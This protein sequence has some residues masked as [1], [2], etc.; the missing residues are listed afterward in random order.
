M[1]GTACSAPELAGACPRRGALRPAP[2]SF[3][4]ALPVL[5]PPAVRND[6]DLPQNNCGGVMEVDLDDNWSGTKIRV[7]GQLQKWEYTEIRQGQPR[8][9][10]GHWKKAARCPRGRGSRAEI[11]RLR[12]EAM[13]PGSMLRAWFGG[14][15]VLTT[16]HMRSQC[17]A[18]CSM[19]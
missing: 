8:A 7:R 2:L 9:P 11:R 3:I 6:I 18:P 19:S 17:G 16:N 4:P 14:V 13:L 12:I 5:L 1:G 10:W 15:Q